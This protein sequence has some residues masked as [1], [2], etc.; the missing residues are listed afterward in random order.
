MINKITLINRGKNIYNK[1]EGVLGIVGPCVQV[2]VQCV[3]G[4]IIPA[5][6]KS[7][8]KCYKI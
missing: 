2:R 6:L 4:P 7:L 8:T 1:S 3:H 5:R